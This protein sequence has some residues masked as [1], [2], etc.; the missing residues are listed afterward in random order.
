M[1]EERILIIKLTYDPEL[2]HGND[3]DAIDWFEKDIL[4][5]E[6]ILHSNELGDEVGRVE[7]LEIS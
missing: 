1:I 5:G 7:V 2:M 3:P 4:G 6:L